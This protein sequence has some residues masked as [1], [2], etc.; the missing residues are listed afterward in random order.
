LKDR[1]PIKKSNL[2]KKW[3]MKSE[4]IKEI[5]D[6]LERDGELKSE[7]VD[8]M[9]MDRKESLK[10]EREEIT[11]SIG[12]QADIFTDGSV[13]EGRAGSA[14]IILIDN[15]ELLVLKSRPNG[16]QT[17][18][19]AELWAII[20]GIKHT[21]YINDKTIYTDS[22]YAIK[23]STLKKESWF[24]TPNSDL[25]QWLQEL[26]EKSQTKL[27]K[28]KAHSS[29]S[30]EA[31]GNNLA[32]KMA[33]EA[34]KGEITPLISEQLQENKI[35]FI[36]NNMVINDMKDFLNQLMMKENL[37]EANKTRKKYMK[38]QNIQGNCKKLSFR[39]LKNTRIK[40]E[41]RK[42][43]WS[44]RNNGWFFRKKIVDEA[45]LKS[46][47][48][49]KSHKETRK[50]V[51]WSCPKLKEWRENTIHEIYK[52]IMD[53]NSLDKSDYVWLRGT[54]YST[55]VK[56]VWDTE[57]QNN[58]LI[59]SIGI[60]GSITTRLLSMIDLGWSI[61]EVRARTDKI[62]KV[63]SKHIH[64]LFKNQFVKIPSFERE[65]ESAVVAR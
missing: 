28:V 56:V 40:E 62:H 37:D 26:L 9:E 17:I 4:L 43:L 10:L 64:D 52:A 21:K 49:C 54:E 46:C 63:I 34:T 1:K 2:K 20:I 12:K 41:H 48:F 29:G 47:R 32:D 24:G 50:H 59:I 5:K 35:Y 19:R 6:K 14:A 45:K 44:L 55:Q 42:C 30:Y 7:I 38:F 36:Y 39:Y 25:I 16:L 13:I 18:S 23:V 31:M 65:S 22:S 58:P 15:T 33:K 60:C 27:T 11:H 8:L 51:I 57:I 53:N 61:D 3:N